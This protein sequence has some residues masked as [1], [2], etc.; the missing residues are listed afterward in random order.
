MRRLSGAVAPPR[1]ASKHVPLPGCPLR[2]SQAPFGS[3][4]PAFNR[5]YETTTTAALA[6]PPASVSLAGGFLRFPCFAHKGCGKRIRVAWTLMNRCRP[7]PVTFEGTVRTLPASQDTPICLCPALRPRPGLHTPGLRPI[8][9][10]SYYVHGGA[11]LPSTNRK[12]LTI[13]KIS[14]FN[15]TALALAPYA[16]CVP[17]G[18]AT[19]CS[20]PSGCQ[21][22]S[23]G[24]DL[25]TGYRLHVSS[26][27]LWFPHVLVAGAMRFF[28]AIPSAAFRPKVERLDPKPLV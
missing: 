16:S 10:A 14:G 28:A 22:F 21:P 17:C 11:A 2:Y 3:G 15:H 13:S 5:Y 18:N 7:F 26:S 23:G 19:Q 9:V 25:P 1:L 27:F 12:A 24:S 8:K 6:N 20:L 4:S